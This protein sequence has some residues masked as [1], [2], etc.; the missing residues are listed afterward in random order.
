MAMIVVA[1]AIVVMVVVIMALGV[2]MIAVVVAFAVI[3]IAVIFVLAVVVAVIMA[4]FVVELIAAEMFLPPFVTAPVGVLAAH[5]ERTA[6]AEVRIE[7]MVDIA[8]ETYRSVEPWSCAKEHAAD[9]P[10][11]AVVAKWGTL[12]RRIVEIAVRT[13]RRNSDADA[14]LRGGFLSANRETESSEN[15]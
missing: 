1:V 11:R 3:V 5:G 7:V 8:V 15:G 13:D 4:D 6:I 14:D 2:A 9:K 12:V 10:L